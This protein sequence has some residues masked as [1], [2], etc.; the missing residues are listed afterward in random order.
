MLDEIIYCI[1]FHPQCQR[2]HQQNIAMQI[3]WLDKERTLIESQVRDRLSVDGP[4]QRTRLD[5]GLIF[6]DYLIHV[7]QTI[8]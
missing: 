6:C 5:L 7:K 1:Y 3:A 8:G 2:S 4:D